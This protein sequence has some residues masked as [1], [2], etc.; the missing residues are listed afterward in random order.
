M[1]QQRLELAREAALLQ[2]D[3]QALNEAKG[4]LNNQAFR[5]LTCL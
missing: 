3:G 1:A 5:N 2:R 4:V